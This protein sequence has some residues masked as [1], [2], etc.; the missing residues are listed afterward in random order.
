MHLTFDTSTVLTQQ[1]QVAAITN[2]NSAQIGDDGITHFRATISFNGWYLRYGTKEYMIS[3]II[4]EAMHAIFTLRWGQYLEW[5]QWGPPNAI[6]SFF[7]KLHFPIQWYY[8]RNQAVPLNELQDHEIMGTDYFQMHSNLLSQ[9]WNPNSSPAMRDSVIKAMS[10][11]GITETTAWQLLPS[12]GIDTC[13]YKAIQLSSETSATGNVT[14]VGC[15]SYNY[16]YANY[17]QL[18]PGCN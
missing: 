16:H 10:Y 3:T 11:G 14:P 6:D 17:L 18:R 4:H 2:T 8:L 5:L 12:Q 9:F 7:I 1:G 15:S 13:K